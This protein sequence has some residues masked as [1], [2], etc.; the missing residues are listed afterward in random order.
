[1]ER[2]SGVVRDGEGERKGE[3]LAERMGRWRHERTTFGGCNDD[4]DVSWTAL[5]VHDVVDEGVSCIDVKVV[6]NGGVRMGNRA[7][8]HHDT[9]RTM[10]RTLPRHVHEHV[11]PS[12]RFHASSSVDTNHVRR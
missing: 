1:M 5:V 12:F 10:H 2:E 8:N 4:V 3:G 6:A 7:R 11:F 9:K